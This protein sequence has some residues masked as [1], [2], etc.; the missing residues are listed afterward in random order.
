MLLSCTLPQ[1]QNIF[2]PVKQVVAYAEVV[3]H[4]PCLLYVCVCV[5]IASPDVE[6]ETSSATED[7]LHGPSHQHRHETTSDLEGKS[8]KTECCK[9]EPKAKRRQRHRQTAVAAANAK[10]TSKGN[11][12]RQIPKGWSKGKVQLQ[13]K[14]KGR[15][16]GASQVDNLQQPL[17][18]R[19]PLPR[20]TLHELG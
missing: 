2:L 8:C 20:H 4:M 3:V 12:Q 13:R 18:G 9:A 15:G 1:W 14:R 7:L 17:A 11:V 19:G 10:G 6:T 16:Q 5:M